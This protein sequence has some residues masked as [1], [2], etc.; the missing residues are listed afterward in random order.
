MN[1][2][3]RN[4]V[5][6]TIKGVLEWTADYFKTKG[7]ATGRLDA[8][9][10]LAHCLC[11]D[12]LHLYLNMD[13]P[14]APDER[15]RFRGLIRRRAAR[16]PVALITGQKE[17]WSLR[18]RTVPG[19]LIPRPDTEILVEAILDEIRENPSPTVME[20]GTGSGAVAISIAREKPSA[21]VLATD[22]D[23]LAASMA[24]VNAQSAGATREVSFVVCDL[25]GA[26]QQT[27]TFD[28][29]CSNPPYI[30]HDAIAGL[31]PEITRFEPIRAL[32]GGPDGLDIIRE[33]VRQASA[34]LKPGGTLFLE[35]GDSQEEA[36]REIFSSLGGFRDIRSIRDLSGTPRVVKGRR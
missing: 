23:P 18:L 29:V 31:E 10:L 26:I 4:C 13:R 28:V 35:I 15:T 5:R 6:W 24:S 27:P 20:I 3:E 33:I 32:D 25:F 36:V 30:P 11:V 2:Q 9:V 21:L 1:D 34:Y 19:I 7:I 8:E 16:E 12:R 22:V 17:F 14:L